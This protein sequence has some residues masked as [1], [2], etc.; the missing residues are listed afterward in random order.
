MIALLLFL[1]LSA[2]AYHRVTPERGTLAFG[3]ISGT[4]TGTANTLKTLV[5]DCVKLDLHNATDVALVVV[6]NGVDIKYMPAGFYMTEDLATNGASYAAADV[7]KVYR[8]SGAPTVGLMEL[9]CK[10]PR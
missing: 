10:P 6:L 2:P 3:A 8:F 4:T 9:V 7:F 5:K 1:H